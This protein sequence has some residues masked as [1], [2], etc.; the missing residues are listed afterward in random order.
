MINH[1]PSDGD[2][3]AGART[4]TGTILTIPANRRYTGNIQMSASVTTL[5]TGTP[6]VSI[7]GTGTG[8]EP[9][10]TQVLA[11]LS[12]SGLS[13]AT[14]TGDCYQEI[15]VAAGDADATLEFNTGGATTASVAVIGFLL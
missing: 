3:R 11:R 8:I 7:V 14:I 1:Q 4:T 5:T 12:I 6:N 15:T 9:A 13:L 2:I 10:T